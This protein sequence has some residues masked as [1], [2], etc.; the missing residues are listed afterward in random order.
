M[1]Q[2]AKVAAIEIIPI[3]FDVPGHEL[4]LTTFVRT[5]EDT[6]AV[7]RSLNNELFNGELR[8]EI[9]VLPPEEGSFLNRLKVV[10]FGGA[11]AIWFFAESDIGKAYIEG[12]TDHEPAHWAK[13]AGEGTKRAIQPSGKIEAVTSEQERKFGELVVCKATTG[14]LQKGVSELER[15]GVSRERFREA[16]EARNSFYSACAATPQLKAVGFT[17]GPT[18]PVK[19]DDFLRLQTALPPKDDELDHPWFV[20]VTFLQVTS[21]NWAREDRTR[22]WK[23]RDHQ[24]RDRFFRIE[25]EEFWA[26]VVTGTISTH[27]IDTIKVQWA[28]QGRAENPKNCRV[29]R[30]LEFNGEV[31]AEPLADDA[32]RAQ[33]GRLAKPD[34]E[35]GLLPFFD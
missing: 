2:I 11:A 33:L 12:L 10:L 32:L 20:D 3:H 21:P 35:E 8:F 6:E 1:A 17:T 29:L 15:V 23:G 30:V 14:F 22:N 5:S 25:D 34:A 24:R 16:F 13:L 31:L 26:R 27:I 28:Y 4:P 7:I 9:L 19:R 18:F